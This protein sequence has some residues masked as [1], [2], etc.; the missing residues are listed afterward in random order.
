MGVSQRHRVCQPLLSFS[1]NELKER[2]SETY[3]V[4]QTITLSELEPWA[5]SLTADEESA[6]HPTPPFACRKRVLQVH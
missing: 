6:S 4:T 5:I 1:L 2:K 3:L